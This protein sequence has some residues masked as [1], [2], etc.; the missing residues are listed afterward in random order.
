MHSLA[1]YKELKAVTALTV[2]KSYKPLSDKQIKT[3]R[4]AFLN[5]KD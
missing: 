3:T 4:K 5:E 2:T 1:T